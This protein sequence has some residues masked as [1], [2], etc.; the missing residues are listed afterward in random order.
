M[1]SVIVPAFNERCTLPRVL[2]AISRALPCVEKEVILV[3]DGSVDGTREWITS[4]FAAGARSAARLNLDTA[5]NLEF[6]DEGAAAQ[7]MIRPVFHPTNRGKGAALATG[8]AAARGRVV[9]IQDADLEYDPADWAPMYDA[10]AIRRDSDVVFG[11]RFIGGRA[12]W[13]L[14]HHLAANRLLSFLFRLLYGLPVSDVE[15]CYK[16]MSAEVK[17]TLD[18]TCA[19]FGCE[20]QLSAQIALARRWR[21]SEV[22]IRYDGRSHAEGKKIGWRDGLEAVLLLLAFRFGR[23]RAAGGPMPA[24]VIIYPPPAVRPPVP[25]VAEAE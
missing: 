4:Q 20:I 8:L 19:G 2:V 14:P 7:T 9:V 15:V 16:M 3:D 25:R 1:L 23:M 24:P 6:L 10:I 22:G 11:S 13:R 21:V 18:I 12:R 17:D 5:G